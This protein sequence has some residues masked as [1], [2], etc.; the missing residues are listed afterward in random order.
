MTVTVGDIRFDH[1][2]YDELGDVLY[3]RRGTPDPNARAEATPEGR[4]VRYD[5]AG[6]VL[7][8]TIVNA[9]WL[10]DRDGHITINAPRPRARSARIGSS[11]PLSPGSADP[12]TEWRG[13][14]AD[15]RE[16]DGTA[17]RSPSRSG[18]FA[19]GTSIAELIEALREA[20]GLYLAKEGPVI[21]TAPTVASVRLFVPDEG[22]QPA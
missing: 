7:A 1:V 19:S 11:A 3:L 8:L 10:Q 4:A 18:R 20:V 16:E 5:E 17:A 14:Q 12:A 2:S 22:L 21:A 9:K 15:I 6:E 13:L